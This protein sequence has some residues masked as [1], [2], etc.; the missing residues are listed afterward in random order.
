MRLPAEFFFA[1]RFGGNHDGT[2]IFAKA[3]ATIEQ[4]VFIAQ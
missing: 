2:I 4:D 1:Q 3:G